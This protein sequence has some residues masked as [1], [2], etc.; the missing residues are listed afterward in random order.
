MPNEQESENCIFC[1]LPTND[2]PCA[3]CNEQDPFIKEEDSDKK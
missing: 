1:G 2:G 3:V